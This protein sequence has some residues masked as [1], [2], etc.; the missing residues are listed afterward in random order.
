MR[1]L[2]GFQRGFGHLSGLERAGEGERDR[3]RTRGRRCIDR[4]ILYNSRVSF[5]G[6][7]THYPDLQSPPQNCFQGVG[8]TALVNLTCNYRFSCFFCWMESWRGWGHASYVIGLMKVV[9]GCLGKKSEWFQ[10]K[11]FKRPRVDLGQRQS[12]SCIHIYIHMF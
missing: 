1:G 3:E 8:L 7:S 10:S 11:R 2:N 9:I 12:S 6:G 4:H 5:E